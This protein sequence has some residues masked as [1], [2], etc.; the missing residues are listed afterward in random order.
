MNTS[1]VA[2]AVVKG[3]TALQGNIDPN[4]LYDG[5]GAI[6]REV[7]RLCEEFGAWI[8]NLGHGITP[9]LNPEDLK[10]LLE[11]VHEYS[12]SS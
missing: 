8:A 2:R 3:R 10:W 4:I 9:G 1:T 7:K 11:C 5:R 12:V 6:E